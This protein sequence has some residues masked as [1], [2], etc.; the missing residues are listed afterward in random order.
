MIRLLYPFIALILNSCSNSTEKMDRIKVYKPT[1]QYTKQIQEKRRVA[2]ILPLS[3]KKKA[4]GKE[5]LNAC[6]LAID[7]YKKVEMLVIDS[8]FIVS[9]PDKLAA[10]LRRNN[11]RYIIGP[12]FS[13]ETIKMNNLL[14][15][16]YYFS[17]SNNTNIASPNIIIGGEDPKD[18]IK[19]LF[20]YVLSQGNQ[21]ILALIPKNT[22]GDMVNSIIDNLDTK[23]SYIRKIRYSTYKPS[24]IQDQLSSTDFDAVFLCENINILPEIGVPYLMPHAFIKNDFRN[25]ISTTPDSRNLKR[26]KRYYSLNYGDTPSDIALIGYDLAN[27]VFSI[28]DK[29]TVD[30]IN[31]PYQGVLGSFY[32][33]DNNIIKRYW[34][35]YEQQE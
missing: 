4:I 2:A 21:K 29:N 19:L 16:L 27:I 26:F 9:N 31:R 5:V 34:K 10:F 25:V 14:G 13:N 24:I 3:G 35:I 28:C 23:N 22:Y 1:N 6:L 8:K 15:N 32:I 20:N 30:I 17:L 18:E 7:N 11:V 12:I 33:A